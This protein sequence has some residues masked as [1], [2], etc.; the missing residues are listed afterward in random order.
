MKAYPVPSP[1]SGH[2]GKVMRR[3]SCVRVLKH[4]PTSE[5][6]N[7]DSNH[8]QTLLLC[9]LGLHVEHLNLSL[10]IH[11]L[12]PR[13]CKCENHVHTT[14]WLNTL[15]QPCVSSLHKGLA[16]LMTWTACLESVYNTS[17]NEEEEKRTL[18]KELHS[19]LP[20]ML[21]NWFYYVSLQATVFSLF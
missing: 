9:F 12:T 7:K 2:E 21:P 1:V 4:S 20:D 15:N 17:S 13:D 16:L 8:C 11:L 3:G 5:T 6:L 19:S 10:L 18:K 14:V